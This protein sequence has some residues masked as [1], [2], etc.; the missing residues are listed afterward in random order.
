MSDHT[1]PLKL[2]YKCF[3]RPWIFTLSPAIGPPQN[4]SV[5]LHATESTG[6][7]QVSNSFSNFI[8]YNYLT[9]SFNLLNFHHILN[10]LQDRQGKIS[11]FL[12]KRNSWCF[13]VTGLQCKFLVHLSIGKAYYNAKFCSSDFLNKTRER[14]ST[15]LK[16]SFFPNV[17]IS[18]R[19]K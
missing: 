11:V 17:I 2:T 16:H 13:S 9:K 6:L 18:S 19:L 14:T 12:S 7:D 15:C 1:E 5:V 3:P 8:G 4:H 10:S